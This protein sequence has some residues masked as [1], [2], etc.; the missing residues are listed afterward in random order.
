MEK[1]V[2][3]CVIISAAPSSNVSYIKNYIQDGDFVICADGAYNWAK[4]KVRID[5]NLGDFDSAAEIPAPY[6]AKVFPA[7]KNFTDGEIALEK[8]L[9]FAAEGK[10]DGIEIYGGGGGREDHFIGNLHLLYRACLAGVGCVM[11]TN[12]ALLSMHRGKFI[13]KNVQGKTVS[14]LPFGGDAHILTNRGLFYPTEDLTLVYGSCRGISNVGVSENVGEI[15]RA[16]A[17]VIVAGSS[18]FKAADRRAAI[19]A[20]RNN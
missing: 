18:V 12:H 10:I 19:R 7:E 15:K 20:L 9:S 6:P 8:M 16:G 4:G 14:L 2:A 13:L 1:K 3:A 11:A 17:N 5:E